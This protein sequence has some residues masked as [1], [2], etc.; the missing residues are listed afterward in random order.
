VLPTVLEVL[1]K[2]VQFT[3]DLGDVKARYDGVHS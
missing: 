2:I 1:I 3:E